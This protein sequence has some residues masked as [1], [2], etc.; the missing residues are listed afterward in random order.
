MRMNASSFGRPAGSSSGCPSGF[1]GGGGCWAR[2]R[3][4]APD[5]TANATSAAALS[6]AT[7]C[8]L[9]L[10]THTVNQAV[11]Q[12]V[13]SHTVNGCQLLTVDCQLSFRTHTLRRIASR[14]AA[15]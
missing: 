1:G 7:L 3:C 9:I 12:P 5:V 2:P 4:C 11:N 10:G 15:Q 8:E 13:D 6:A 14:A